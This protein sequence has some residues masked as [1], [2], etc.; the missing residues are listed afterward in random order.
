MQGLQLSHT[1]TTPDTAGKAGATSRT[2]AHRPTRLRQL[3]QQGPS[4]P[5]LCKWTDRS[6]QDCGWQSGWQWLPTAA[7]LI[8]VAVTSVVGRHQ[9]CKVS[10]WIAA[11]KGITCHRCTVYNDHTC[12]VVGLS[13]IVDVCR[14]CP[15]PYLWNRCREGLRTVLAALLTHHCWGCICINASNVGG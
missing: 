7:S 14:Q 3:Q 15:L 10:Q 4:S 6:T 2:A 13:R 12:Q 11:P 8:T 9:L 1:L 5:Q